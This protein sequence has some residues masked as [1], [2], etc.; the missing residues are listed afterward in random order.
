MGG[1]SGGKKVEGAVEVEKCQVPESINQI[2]S[3]RRQSGETDKRTLAGEWHL[4][5]AQV[6]AR[7][8][9]GR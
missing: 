2:L 9:V 5:C 3:G 1:G 8:E 6:Q 7:V 4:T